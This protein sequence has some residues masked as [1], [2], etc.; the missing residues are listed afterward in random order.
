MNTDD[1]IQQAVA[2]IEENLGQDLSLDDLSKKTGY[3]KF[4]LSRLFSDI[5]GCTIYKYIKMRR[6]TEAARRL[7][8]TEAAIIDIAFEAGYQSQQAFTNA[9]T[10]IYQCSPQAYRT[11]GIFNPKMKRY[12]KFIQMGVRLHT[13]RSYA[14]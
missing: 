5:T 6:I 8:D 3:S 9:F 12:G 14:A 11:A 1:I 4:Y 7:T 2:Y 13:V 10:H